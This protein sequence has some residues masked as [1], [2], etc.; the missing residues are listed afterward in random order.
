MTPADAV[1]PGV[2]TLSERLRTLGGI[3]RRRWLLLLAVPLA[4]AL[5]AGFVAGQQTKRYESTAKLLLGDSDLVPSP[6]PDTS[7]GG[8]G[9]PERATNT[10]VGLIKLEAVAA[11]VRDRLHV[12]LTPEELAKKVTTTVEGTSSIV[13]VTATDST[14]ARAAVVANAFAGEY[15]RFRMQLAQNSLLQAERAIRERLGA[16]T[17]A[18]RTSP[19]GSALASRLRSLSLDAASQTGGVEVVVRAIPPRSAAGP[20]PVKA[21]AIGLVGGLLLA[22]MAVAGLELADRRIKDEEDVESTFE[23]RVLAYIPRSAARSPKATPSDGH[24]TNDPGYEKVAGYLTFV[25]RKRPVGAVMVTSPSPGDGK[26]SAVLGVAWAL[27]H[28]GKRVIVIDADLRRPTLAGVIGINGRRG[29]TQSVIW[30]SSVTEQLVPLDLTTMRPLASGAGAGAGANGN[31]NGNGRRRRP[32]RDGSLAVLPAGPLDIPAPEVLSDQRMGQAIAHCRERADFVLIDTPPIGAFPDATLLSE[33]VDAAIVVSR[34]R[35]T[36]RDALRR[37]LHELQ[38]LAMPVLGLVV[39]GA[40]SRSDG[41]HRTDGYYGRSAETGGR[42]ARAPDGD[43]PADD[44]G[45]PSLSPS[46]NS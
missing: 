37:S 44:P 25:A 14:P 24:D 40:S 5:V 45:V 32:H 41:Y 20:K 15:V 2:P 3:A 28:L 11:R 1:T 13:D 26:S 46:T 35:W 36:R 31:G 34:L 17:P 21:A 29:L 4:A 16:L 42:E 39:T 18:Q 6:S 43:P 27:A 12:R 9:D 7:S 33:G 10:K 8:P 38:A 22:L 19:A 30:G 23:T